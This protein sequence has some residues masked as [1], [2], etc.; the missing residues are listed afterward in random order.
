M[1]SVFKV[2]GR[3]LSISRKYSPVYILLA[4]LSII[5]SSLGIGLAEALRRM[6]NAGVEKDM[7][8]L[9]IAT[10]LSVGVV[11]LQTF[12]NWANTYLYSGLNIKSVT[13]LQT[14]TLNKLHDTNLKYI[15]RY[16]TGDLT[17]RMM[18]SA[19]EAQKGMNVHCISIITNLL[20][21]IFTFSYLIYL[22]IFL[23]LGA[24]IIA[25]LLPL[26]I[27][28]ISKYIRSNYD[29]RNQAVANS[30]AMMQDAVEGAE[31][32]RAY[33]ATDTLL[34]KYKQLIAT[35]L[36]H[37]TK[38]SMHEE[39]YYKFQMMTTFFALL[40]I[41]GFGGYLA[42]QGTLDVGA[43]A[44]FLVVFERLSRPFSD[45][46]ASWIQLQRSISHANRVFELID[47]PRDTEYRLLEPQAQDFPQISGFYLHE[48][49]FRYEDKPV[50]TN[51]SL[52]I[53]KNKFTAIVGP[54][55]SGK[56]TLLYLLLRLYNPE[57]GDIY[58]DGKSMHSFSFR[59]WTNKI[60]YVPQEPFI[61]SDNLVENIRYGNV[62]AP[63]P[64]VYVAATQAG[65]RHLLPEPHDSRTA[66]DSS[67]TLSGG[68]KQRIAIARAL[69]NKDCE[70]LIMD[71]A[72]SRL[73][74]RNEKQV[75]EALKLIADGKTCIMIAHRLNLVQFADEII[76]MEDG[77]VLE[78]GSHGELYRA[79]G[80]Y[81]SL[82]TKMMAEDANRVNEGS[83]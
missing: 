32:I 51:L 45:L 54:S 44:A 62:N 80:N 52:H 77:Q 75:F 12:L 57:S 16:H 78:R 27:S 5:S 18:E 47:L 21:I 25:V 72:T 15:H 23:T 29:K 69:V 34:R 67:R 56:S 19:E 6:I 61:F 82:Y 30:E 8:L 53:A 59:E 31:V 35:A 2:L 26:A 28:P 83:E 74:A 7:G 17:S 40:Y 9:Y 68:E 36:K 39:F 50:F 10:A 66:E 63:D 37:A 4:I 64:A 71:E 11:I 1:Y 70:I 14:H 76:Y 65:I 13:H 42:Y 46:S 48:V 58:F 38:A 22:N 33:S 81:Y 24:M 20:Q 79:R 55:G 60:A 3:L 49:T 73:D 41:F 43:I